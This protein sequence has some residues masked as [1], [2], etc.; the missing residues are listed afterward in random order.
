MFSNLIHESLVTCQVVKFDPEGMLNN[1]AQKSLFIGEN[2]N[3]VFCS[4]TPVPVPIID[5]VPVY[6]SRAVK[7]NVPVNVSFISCHT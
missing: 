5:L 2:G 1:Y 4:S 6:G 7:V 3:G